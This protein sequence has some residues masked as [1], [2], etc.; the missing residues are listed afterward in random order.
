[1]SR[2]QEP[3]ER[4]YNLTQLTTGKSLQFE[5]QKSLQSLQFEQWNKVVLNIIQSR[6][7]WVHSILYKWLNSN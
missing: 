4:A 2:I 5:Q 3:H 7:E 6:A 1:M